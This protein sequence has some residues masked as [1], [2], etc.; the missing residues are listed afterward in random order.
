MKTAILHPLSMGSRGRYA[1]VDGI[2]VGLRCAEAGE[3]ADALWSMLRF[4]QA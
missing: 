4:S 3:A 2:A 1:L